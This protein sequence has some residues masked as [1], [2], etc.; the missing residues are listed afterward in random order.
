MTI[1]ITLYG[2][3]DNQMTWSG[4][5]DDMYS[6]FL[7]YFERVNQLYRDYILNIQKVNESYNESI[8]IIER[9]NDT[10]KGL[11]ENYSKMSQ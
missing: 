9:M 4:S 2:D 7:T 5:G 6:G 8:R 1:C 11:I 3:D 10:C